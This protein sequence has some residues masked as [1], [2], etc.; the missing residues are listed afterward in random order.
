MYPQA[1]F[2]TC[3]EEVCSVRLSVPGDSEE[4]DLDVGQLLVEDG[5]ALPM[6]L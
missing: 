1:V 2:L 3:D 4:E 5:R 6:G